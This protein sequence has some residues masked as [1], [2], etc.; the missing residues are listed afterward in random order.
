MQKSAQSS[1]RSVHNW[2]NKNNPGSL[3]AKKAITI[4]LQHY[5]LKFLLNVTPFLSALIANLFINLESTFPF[6]YSP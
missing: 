1:D 2:A 5:L 3:N 6:F 4:I